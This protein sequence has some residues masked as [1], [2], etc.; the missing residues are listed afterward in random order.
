VR[1]SSEAQQLHEERADPDAPKLTHQSVLA[2][3]LLPPTRVQLK[4]LPVVTIICS[5][6]VQN[7]AEQHQESHCA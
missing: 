1:E 5:D 4:R 6:S 2:P 3:F 7:D